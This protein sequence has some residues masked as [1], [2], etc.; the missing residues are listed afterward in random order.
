[1]YTLIMKHTFFTIVCLGLFIFADAGLLG[2]L[3]IELTG[4]ANN[5]TFHPDRVTAHSVSTNYKKFQNYPYGF[6]DFHL[7]GEVSEKMDFDVHL[8][9]DNILQ[10]TLCGRIKTTSDYFN[11]EFGPFVG[12]TDD[13]E[14]PEA[15]IMGNM[16]VAYPGIAFI[17]VGG[18][19]SLGADF[20]FL[21][22]NTRETAEIKV[23]F[24]LPSVIP[25]FSMNTKKYSKHLVDSVIIRDELTRVQVSADFFA[26][27]SPVILTF[28]AGYETLSR[29]YIIEYY[30]IKDELNAVFIG[31][32]LKWQLTKPLRLIAGFEIPFTYSAEEPM[33]NP[34]DRF[35]L[36]K[37][38]GGISYNVFN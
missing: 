16:Q 7:K 32:N 25:Y 34:D 3:E 29:A 24:W 13:F 21:S 35:K 23:G 22:N 37:F 30:E 26:K 2:A 19:S 38:Y 8:F 12:I 27:N 14:K 33:K 36:Y 18:S 17:F 31:A 4:G 6:G 9:R 10:N 5:M 28:D 15:G 20:D 1:M 11:I